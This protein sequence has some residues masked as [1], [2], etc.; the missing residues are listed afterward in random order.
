M[1]MRLSVTGME[2]N[3]RERG[4]GGIDKGSREVRVRTN[5]LKP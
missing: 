4:A 3:V 5:I 2:G 1:Q